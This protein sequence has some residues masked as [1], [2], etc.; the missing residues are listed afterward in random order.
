MRGEITRKFIGTAEPTSSPTLEYR[1]HHEVEAPEISERAFRPGWRRHTRLV[2][3]LET[4]KISREA[5]IAGIQWRRW[6]EAIG[7][8][9]V[10]KWSARISRSLSPDSPTPFQITAATQLKT[11]ACA[12][13][14]Y[15]TQVLF[16][17]LIDDF[18]WR[19]L[20]AKLHL[21]GKTALVRTVESLEALAAWRAG[22]PVPKP[23]SER[24]RNQPASW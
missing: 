3:L 13:G 5:F 10:Q 19:Q 24:F 17:H 18:S 16:A 14:E 2:A 12:L 8:M 20:G 23:P 4:N 7:K 1:R 15:R 9:P 6:T 21:D 11:A 22:K